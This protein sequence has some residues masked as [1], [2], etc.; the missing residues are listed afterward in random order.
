LSYANPQSN[1]SFNLAFNRMGPRIVFIGNNIQTFTVYELP[2]NILDLTFG[3][4]INKWL[5]LEVSVQ[6]IL[7][8]QFMHVQDVNRDEKLEPFEDY[9]YQLGGDNVYRAYYENPQLQLTARFKIQ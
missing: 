5:H 7:N 8:A 2:R 6:N 1:T 9:D 3:Q 4:K